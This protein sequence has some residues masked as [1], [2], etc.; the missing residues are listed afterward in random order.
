MNYK[1][2][3]LKLFQYTHNKIM[4][5]M[6][7]EPALRKNYRGVTFELINAPFILYRHRYNLF[8]FPQSDGH[9]RMPT[10]RTLQ[11]LSFI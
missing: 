5:G 2:I 9:F 7:F 3:S 11:P 8:D 1:G 6:T 10:H 4:S